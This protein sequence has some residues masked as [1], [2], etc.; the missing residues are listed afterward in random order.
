VTA[1]AGPQ[2]GRSVVLVDTSAWTIRHLGTEG[3]SRPLAVMFDGD[4]NLYV[5]DFGSFEVDA[6]GRVL[7]DP[8]SGKLWRLPLES[9]LP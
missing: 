8:G 7:A 4:G 2:V 9:V 6:S 3:L 1:P 5:V